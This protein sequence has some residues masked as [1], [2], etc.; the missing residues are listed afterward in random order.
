MIKPTNKKIRN[1][2]A[3]DSRSGISKESTSQLLRKQK[4][5]FFCLQFKT[6]TLLSKAIY[7]Q[8]RAH[9]GAFL[10]ASVNVDRP[11]FRSIKTDRVD[12]F[13]NNVKTLNGRNNIRIYVYINTGAFG[14]LFKYLLITARDDVK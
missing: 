2:V 8:I 13:L 11:M 14:L 4:T 6:R 7:I 9:V 12:Y 10:A 3:L 1:F 5:Y